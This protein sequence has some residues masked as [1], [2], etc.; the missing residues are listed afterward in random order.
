M[1]NEVEPKN[2]YNL[3]F[4]KSMKW[5]IILFVIFIISI[6]SKV[7]ISSKI[8]ST[9]RTALSSN[10]QCPIRFDNYHFEIFLPKI[11]IKNL[12]IPG[13]CLRKYKDINLKQVKLHFR[14]LSF[15]PFGPHFKLETQFKKS[16]LEIY[17]TTGLS[18]VS[19]K[20]EKELSGNKFKSISNTVRL[21]DINEFIPNLKLSG[22]IHLSSL[23]LEASYTGQIQELFVNATSDN[24]ALPA[25]Q[26]SMFNTP[27]LKI[28]DLLIK[29]KGDNKTIDIES[30]ILGNEMSPLIAN[31]KGKIN[32]NPRLISQSQLNLKGE[33]AFGESF[34]DKDIQNLA[35]S[36]LGQFDLKDDKY[37]QIQILGPLS[38]P[39]FK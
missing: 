8:D 18:S 12:I 14:G 25:Q 30:L 29:I 4:L 17:L 39:K 24:L 6:F 5:V 7:S 26:V 16:P 33:F 27:N 28:N 32:L 15:S 9:L 20:L 23:F 2:I 31:F 22:D 3:S 36:F 11:V 1:T 38:G 35:K 10:R 19:M 37:Y 34:P 13:K 21:D